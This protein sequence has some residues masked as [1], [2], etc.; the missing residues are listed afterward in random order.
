VTE[1]FEIW[2]KKARGRLK[3]LP[4]T[5]DLMPARADLLKSFAM[6]LAPADLLDRYQVSG[7]FAHWWAEGLPDL[8]ALA[9]HGFGGLIESW[10]TTIRDAFEED[11]GAKS[12]P[13]GHKLVTR[14]LSSYLEEVATADAKKAE[15]EAQLTA[16]ET[17]DE[18]N[19]ES[20][21]EGETELTPQQVNE[22]KKDLK[23]AKARVKELKKGLLNRLTQ[24]AGELDAGTREG[25]VVGIFHD[26]LAGEIERR[27][28]AHRQ[29]IIDR[30]EMWWD[31][32]R[33]TAVSLE[34]DR[35]TA[36]QRLAGFLAELGYADGRR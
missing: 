2:W 4:E 22:L 17:N 9:A 20:D 12:D 30:V 33:I 21:S 3:A 36:A 11:G 5:R 34:G 25:L 32:Y 15:I 10:V 35:S 14:L 31:K 23:E 27:V 16:A 1:A 26:D 29:S 28:V 13:L 19:G 7:A 6:A 24:K 8:K 18:E